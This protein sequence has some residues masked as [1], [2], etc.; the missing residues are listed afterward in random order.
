MRYLLQAPHFKNEETGSGRVGGWAEPTAAWVQSQGCSP[1]SPG[2]LV[3][4]GQHMAVVPMVSVHL[5]LL[6]VA[7]FS[8]FTR[9]PSLTHSLTPSL[10]YQFT[11][12]FCQPRMHPLIQA[13]PGTPTPHVGQWSQQAVNQPLSS[14]EAQLGSPGAGSQ[15]HCGRKRGK[16]PIPSG[17]DQPGVS[18]SGVVSPSAGGQKV[19]GQGTESNVGS[20]K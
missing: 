4:R 10:S 15:V 9:P 19:R 20:R 5:P 6:Q 3:R 7:G 1:S 13:L 8:S 16:G 18:S 2:P 11:P 14:L 17:P 12:S